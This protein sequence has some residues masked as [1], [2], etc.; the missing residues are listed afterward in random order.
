MI[1]MSSTEERKR[2]ASFSRQCLKHHCLHLGAIAMPRFPPRHSHNWQLSLPSSRIKSQICGACMD[3]LDLSSCTFLEYAKT[4]KVIHRRCSFLA[5]DFAE[6]C[7][8]ADPSN[9]IR[10]LLRDD[11]ESLSSQNRIG[12]RNLQDFVTL[13][14]FPHWMPHFASECGPSVMAFLTFR[15]IRLPPPVMVW[16]SQLLRHGAPKYHGR[17]ATQDSRPNNASP[18]SPTSPTSPKSRL[19]YFGKMHP[20]KECLNHACKP[21]LP[22]HINEVFIQHCSYTRVFFHAKLISPKLHLPLHLQQWMLQVCRPP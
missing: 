19:L 15:N 20:C 9:V 8:V 13:C 12:A 14:A 4:I 2:V 17:R 16:I 11:F 22:T 18:T 1:W 5:I 7:W 10:G 3:F 21:W 6:N